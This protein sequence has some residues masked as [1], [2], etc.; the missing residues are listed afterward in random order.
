MRRIGVLAVAPG[1]MLLVTTAPGGKDSRS[2]ASQS[3]NF[4][5]RA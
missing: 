1:V 4:R 3:S 5:Y 2:K